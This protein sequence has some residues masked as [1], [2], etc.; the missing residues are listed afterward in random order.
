M[1]SRPAES[2]NTQAM[3]TVWVLG[4][5]FSRPL[6]GPLLDDF[7]TQRLDGSLE[8]WVRDINLSLQHPLGPAEE[9]PRRMRRHFCG[10]ARD[11]LETYRHDKELLKRR[12]WRDA[13]EFFELVDIAFSSSP[14][15]SNQLNAT[16]L[17]ALQALKRC[18]SDPNDFG[19]PDEEFRQ[20][21]ASMPDKIRWYMALA[22]EAFLPESAELTWLER[23]SPY[24]RWAAMAGEDDWVLTFNYDR[25]VELSAAAAGKADHLWRKPYVPAQCATKGAGEDDP[26]DST[27]RSESRLL[28]LH[29]STSW[30][31][32]KGEEP[33]ESHPLTFEEVDWSSSQSPLQFM[34]E[35]RWVPALASP[36]LDKTLQTRPEGMFAD[37][38][39]QAEEALL[40]AGAIVF[41]G[42]RFPE[43]DEEAKRRL[44]QA[45]RYN[46]SPVLTV[47]IVLGPRG[48]NASD[49]DRVE[50]MLRWALRN[51]LVAHSVDELGRLKKDRYANKDNK[52]AAILVEPMWA[53]DFLSV[54][55]PAELHG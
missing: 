2:S 21:K 42:Y 39:K 30:G 36:G 18:S 52:L 46:Q 10:R 43:S 17:R 14:A 33:L 4:A 55:D 9:L 26:G 40:N 53:Q 7:F 34:A 32:P 45:I 41:V 51:R 13:E 27:S 6:G 28:K 37:L 24:R 31:I 49:I 1:L 48:R 16:R 44:L 29:G 22:C 54:Y 15:V 19:K 12:P 3:S 35:N 11:D 5:G 20:T 38:W 23:W 8:A 50:G 47:R 25:V